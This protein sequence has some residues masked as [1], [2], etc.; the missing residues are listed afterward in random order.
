MRILYCIPAFAG[1]GAERRMTRIACG[2]VQRG[3]DVHVAYQNEGPHLA[4]AEAAG[5]HCHRLA[6]GRHDPRLLPK[7][8]RL[9]NRVRPDLVQGW[10]PQMDILG[11]VA[12]K[13]RRVPFVMTE[14]SSELNYVPGWKRTIREWLGRHATRAIIAN[15][16]GGAGYWHANGVP[17]EKCIVIPG[18]VSLAEIDAAQPVD[19]R[20]HGLEGLRILLA[21]GRFH[22]DKNIDNLIAGMRLALAD[23]GVAVVVCGEGPRLAD[24]RQTFA[25]ERRVLLPG[26]VPDVFRWMKAA[27]V[28]VSVSRFEG[29]PNAVIEAMA[30]GC[31]VVVSDIPAHREILDEQSAVFVAAEDPPSIA[32]G[33]ARALADGEASA[34][35]A[36]RARATAAAWSN[37]AMVEQYV[38]AYA[39]LVNGGRT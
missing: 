28:F 24:I 9:I 4:T 31:P 17:P 15:S 6:G 2:L 13:M 30:S 10:L 33:I 37:E 32:A 21:V 8:V 35:R 7:L 39:A 1:G 5:V 20:E 25:N 26:F 38:A 18:G 36:A 19:P 11:A 27:A 3:H 12:A 22:S 16:R 34:A 29:R 14:P 23:P